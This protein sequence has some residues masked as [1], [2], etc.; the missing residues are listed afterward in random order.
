MVPAV[1]G[2][3]LLK[4]ACCQPPGDSAVKVTVASCVPSRAQTLPVWV[5][6]LPAPL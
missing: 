1:T 2:T 4:L 3:A 6:E 5:P